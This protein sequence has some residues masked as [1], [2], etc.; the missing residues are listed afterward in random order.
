MDQLLINLI[1]NTVC[2]YIYIHYIYIIIY[3]VS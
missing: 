3:V 2:I 1:M